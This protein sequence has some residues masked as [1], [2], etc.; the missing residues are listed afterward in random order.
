METLAEGATAM[1]GEDVTGW[2]DSAP[3]PEEGITVVTGVC[4]PPVTLTGAES[5]AKEPGD[6]MTLYMVIF[7]D[8]AATGFVV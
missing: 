7:G 6:P 4:P 8:W 2:I 1:M 5:V 3:V